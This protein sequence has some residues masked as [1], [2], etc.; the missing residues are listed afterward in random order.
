MRAV[1]ES[2]VSPEL[3]G[4]CDTTMLL[5]RLEGTR[6]DPDAYQDDFFDAAKPVQAVY[7][8]GESTSE[9]RVDNFESN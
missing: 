1:G 5:S 2:T 9:S 8:K 4:T 6:A 7:R 3:E